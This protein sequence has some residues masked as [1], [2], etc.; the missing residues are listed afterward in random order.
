MAAN[1]IIYCDGACAGNQ[2]SRNIGGWGFVVEREG[3]RFQQYGGEKNTT[4]NRMELTACIKALT[5]VEDVDGR[6][7]LFSD[8]AYL[9][10]CMHKK[11]YVR[12]EKNGWKN[13]SK[14]PVE[15]QDLWEE[16]LRLIRKLDVRFHK[17]KGHAGIELNE[18]ADELANRGMDE[19]TNNESGY[20]KSIGEPLPGKPETFEGIQYRSVPGGYFLR[21][22]RGTGIMDALKTFVTA[23]NIGSG[24]LSAIGA[25]ENID[26]GYYYFDKRQYAKINFPGTYEVISMT[27]N[28][29]YIDGE[30]FV[31]THLALSDDQCQTIG[32]HFFDGRVALTLEVHISVFPEKWTRSHDEET[33]LNLLDLD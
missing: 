28:I 32:G 18:L 2:N 27:G 33:G 17:V 16:V 19:L 29:S 11:W 26:I 8:S 3:Q 23:K 15:N 21:L 30:P 25:I 24:T 7:D 9:V 22:L 12:W 10:N 4:N 20:E 6:I 14:K 31:H 13:A 5:A 1:I